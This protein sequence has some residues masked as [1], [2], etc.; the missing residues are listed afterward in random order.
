MK[1][2]GEET[3]HEGGEGKE[4]GGWKERFRNEWTVLKRMKARA[5]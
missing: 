2:L 5:R 4:R 1:V 3:E